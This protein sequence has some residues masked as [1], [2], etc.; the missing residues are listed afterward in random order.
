MRIEFAADNRKEIMVFTDVHLSNS[1]TKNIGYKS[2]SG[3]L[4]VVP[5]P[6]FDAVTVAEIIYL[7]FQFQFIFR[8]TPIN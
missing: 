7:I 1:D 5:F 2:L 6:V 3:V 8:Y 4:I